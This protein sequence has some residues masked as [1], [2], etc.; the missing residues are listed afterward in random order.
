M[1]YNTYSTNRCLSSFL[2]FELIT[3]NLEPIEDDIVITENGHHN[4]MR[5]IPI[6]TE[7]I[8]DLMNS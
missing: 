6:E 2:H 4:L 7:E 5:N 1:T 3:K 8:E